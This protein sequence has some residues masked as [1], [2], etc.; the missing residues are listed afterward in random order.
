MMLERKPAVSTRSVCRAAAAL[1]PSHEAFG[2]AALCLR[3]LLDEL[4]ERLG[5]PRP[6]DS[7]PKPDLLE[8]V[9]LLLFQP[10]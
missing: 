5:P 8:L 6:A 10:S 2:P 9:R 3:C 1:K 7:S 4:L